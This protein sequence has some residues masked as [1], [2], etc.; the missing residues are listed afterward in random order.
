MTSRQKKD[1][2]E[3]LLAKKRKKGNPD[4]K[5]IRKKIRKKPPKKSLKDMIDKKRIKTTKRKDILTNKIKPAKKKGKP[6]KVTA[7]TLTNNKQI[8]NEMNEFIYSLSEPYT[9]ESFLVSLNTY[10]SQLATNKK[11]NNRIKSQLKRELEKMES[12]MSNLQ[13]EKLIEW[14]TTY[15]QE[16]TNP[17]N[18]PTRIMYNDD[19]EEIGIKV[20]D[21]HQALRNITQSSLETDTKN[22]IEAGIYML[23]KVEDY[24]GG[25]TAT[26]EKLLDMIK[27]HLLKVKDSIGNT[28]KK[29]MINF[30]ITNPKKFIDV[31][32][33]ISENLVGD[34]EEVWEFV[35]Q[36]IPFTASANMQVQN[37]H[38]WIDSLGQKKSRAVYSSMSNRQMKFSVSLQSLISELTR[39][40]SLNRLHLLSDDALKK[41]RDRVGNILTDAHISLEQANAI[42]ELNNQS[43]L[44]QEI[45]M[46][47]QLKNIRKISKNPEGEAEIELH[48][49]IGKQLESIDVDHDTI[50]SDNSTI[51]IVRISDMDDED[52]AYYSAFIA[53]PDQEPSSM[54]VRTVKDGWKRQERGI[55]V[56]NGKIIGK[57]KILKHSW[58][59][60][61]VKELEDI[62][63]D[64]IYKQEKKVDQQMM[65]RIVRA[66]RGYMRNVLHKFLWHASNNNRYFVLVFREHYVKT[67]ITEFVNQ[68]IKSSQTIGDVL[69]KVAG[70]TIF[71]HMDPLPKNRKNLFIITNITGSLNGRQSGEYFRTS[72]LNR[73]LTPRSILKDTIENKLP[74]IFHATDNQNKMRDMLTSGI[75]KEKQDIIISI[76]MLLDPMKVK[77]LHGGFQE[78]EHIR[79]WASKAPVLGDKWNQLSVVLPVEKE[80]AAIIA[81]KKVITHHSCDNTDEN[82]VLYIETVNDPTTG[83]EVKKV[84]CFDLLKLYEKLINNNT[85]NQ[86]SGVEFR[87][88]FVRDIRS[89]MTNGVK[90]LQDSNNIV[91]I[92]KQKLAS[93][94]A[95]QQW[96]RN[97]MDKN[98]VT[99]ET[100]SRWAIDFLL[101][102]PDVKKEIERMK[103]I[104]RNVGIDIDD[105]AAKIVA[106][107]IAIEEKKAV[108]L[109]KQADTF[110]KSISA[111]N[112]DVVDEPVIDNDDEDEGDGQTWEEE[113]EIESDSGSDSEEEEEE[114]NI[115]EDSDEEL[116]EDDSGDKDKICHH[117]KKQ[118]NNGFKTVIDNRTGITHVDIC[119]PCFEHVTLK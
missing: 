16:K 43:N 97:I 117:C 115:M 110:K 10:K 100:D 53:A 39:A 7:S 95:I 54:N 83:Q 1:T 2:L 37:N 35:E 40:E 9:R 71:F 31:I 96:F 12:I 61:S 47:T 106:D 108:E 8:L 103:D 27:T 56:I 85:K 19:G 44:F 114:L 73:R 42:V 46:Y 64:E 52:E 13:D 82:S 20:Q 25:D 111:E 63:T 49:K 81:S 68:A 55:G 65:D 32:F 60:S 17:D 67:F 87:D 105:K 104:K 119:I 77:D 45:V 107:M 14:I 58:I 41:I 4:K 84:Y 98:P 72:V 80:A 102:I 28:A 62:P 11:V 59:P 50:I 5:P 15:Q 109:E 23:P 6:T 76:F 90:N 75:Q 26:E 69:N 34:D 66:I 86:Y 88:D 51:T 89:S 113:E 70:F 57:M 99:W 112:T 94:T 3:D 93:T 38:R 21:V 79:D 18:H 74:I 36:L 24:Q 118:C 78:D 116:A 30:L 22:L 33:W 91:N 92:E 48:K 101:T 29:E